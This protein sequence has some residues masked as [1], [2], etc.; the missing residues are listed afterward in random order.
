MSSDKTLFFSFICTTT[1]HANK[2]RHKLPK[3]KAVFNILSWN[4]SHMEGVFLFQLCWP[5]PAYQGC[6]LANDISSP[7]P[8][9]FG[10]AEL[11]LP[12][13]AG[14]WKQNNQAKAGTVMTVQLLP[15]RPPL[16]HSR[17]HSGNRHRTVWRTSTC[18]MATI[19]RV[20]CR[21]RDKW[22]HGT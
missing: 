11:H 10:K 7:K 22:Y 1:W 6:L 5:L 19:Y 2:E 21:E 14:F 4:G 16:N 13:L 15:E 20:V 8:K 17:N 3:N 9:I 12:V 18:V